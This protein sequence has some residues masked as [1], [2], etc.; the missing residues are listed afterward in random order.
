[1][2]HCALRA[3]HRQIELGLF[4]ASTRLPPRDERARGWDE[5]IDE[6]KL[7]SRKLLP[8]LT[9][10]ATD[11]PHHA[12]TTYGEGRFSACSAQHRYIR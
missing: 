5:L 3:P 6:P 12:I 10:P 7:G 11:W 9:N 1:M 2:S 8:L 4:P